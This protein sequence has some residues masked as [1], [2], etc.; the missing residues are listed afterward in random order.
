MRNILMIAC[1]IIATA[2]SATSTPT[3]TPTRYAGPIT[4]AHTHYFN[5]I[6]K[7][8]GIDTLVKAMDK[9]H[10]SDAIFTGMGLSLQWPSSEKNQPVY[11]LDTDI[12]KVIGDPKTD[13][14]IA[15]SYLKTSPENKHRLHPFACGFNGND[16]NSLQYLK[17]LIW[18]YPGVFQGIGELFAHHDTL[19][20][21]SVQTMPTP[22]A[23]G[24][25]LI[26]QFAAEYKMPV[27]IHSDITTLGKQPQMIYLAQI[28]DTLKANPKTQ[29]IWAHVGISRNLYVP[30]L[31]LVFDKLLQ[32]YPNLDADISWV[33]WEDQLDKD[34]QLDD[35]WIQLIEKYPTRIMIGSDM[36]GNFSDVEIY[37]K[38]IHKYDVLLNRLSAPVAKLVAHDNFLNLLPQAIVLK[39]KDAKEANY[40]DATLENVI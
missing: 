7:S 3:T 10:V 38:T 17:Q 33:C 39:P 32:K 40:I 16:K 30:N 19:G 24:Y 37:D 25:Q 29:F 21:M 12:A 23:L 6:Q 34:N 8:E 35:R 26:Y 4:D 22:D 20:D 9:A 18:T 27:L 31:P 15:T 13:F 11:Y 2:T 14:L 36:V 1:S 28:E 5:F